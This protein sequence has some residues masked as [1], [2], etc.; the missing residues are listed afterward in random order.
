MVGLN[1]STA[2]GTS[3][4]LWKIRSHVLPGVTTG[5][6]NM[7]PNKYR[8]FLAGKEST[9]QRRRPGFDPW[10]GKMPWKKWQPTPVVLPGESHGQRSLAG[11]S[12]RGLKGE[13][14]DLV[15]KQ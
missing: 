4:V 6:N 8:V 13:G 1:T 15:T 7:I 10:V 12:P 14:H 5:K 2:G 9:C 11:Y 3:S